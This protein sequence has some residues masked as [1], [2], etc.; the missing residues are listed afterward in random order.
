[1]CVWCIDEKLSCKTQTSQL[2][3]A[4]KLCGKIIGC[5]PDTVSMSKLFV[6]NHLSWT[7]K[8]STSLGNPTAAYRAASLTATLWSS[9]TFDREARQVP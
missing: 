4:L 2:V 5:G 1:M 3:K 9:C 7:L 8:S 6:Q